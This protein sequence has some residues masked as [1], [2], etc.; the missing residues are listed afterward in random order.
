ME[1]WSM[2]QFLTLRIFLN[3]SLRVLKCDQIQKAIAKR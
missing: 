3:N 1:M 2:H